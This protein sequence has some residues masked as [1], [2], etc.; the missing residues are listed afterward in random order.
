MSGLHTNYSGC[1]SIDGINI[2]EITREQLRKLIVLV[3][4]NLLLFNRTIKEN[5]CYNNTSYRD[6]QL[7]TALRL[8]CCHEFINDSPDGIE[9]K[10]GEEGVL[11]SGGKLKE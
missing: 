7:F 9:T 4:Q 5:I 10:I 2:K 6:E 8:S 11:L 1:I 3:E